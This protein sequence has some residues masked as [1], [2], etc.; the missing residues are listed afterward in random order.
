MDEG[1]DFQRAFGMIVR[2]R[3]QN[4]KMNLEKFSEKTELHLTYLASAERGERNVSMQ[5]I[6]KISK[7]LECSPKDL[8][9]Y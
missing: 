4:L 1:K 3:R 5:N 6:R 8:M 2:L 9:P 7:A